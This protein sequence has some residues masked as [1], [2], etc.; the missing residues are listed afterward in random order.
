MS[1]LT[2]ITTYTMIT[3]SLGGAIEAGSFCGVTIIGAIV[4]VL[5]LSYIYEGKDK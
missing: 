2:N 4:A 5:I 3:V 1:R